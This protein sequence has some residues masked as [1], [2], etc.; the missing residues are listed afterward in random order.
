MA[1]TAESLLEA[2]RRCL[3]PALGAASVA[4]YASEDRLRKAN[5]VLQPGLSIAPLIE[6]PGRSKV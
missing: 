4:V 3:I 2:V 6:S 1:V 5:E